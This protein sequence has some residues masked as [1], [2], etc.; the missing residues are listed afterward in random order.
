MVSQRSGAST[1]IFTSRVGHGWHDALR[2]FSPD[3]VRTYLDP[4]SA[5]HELD[6]IP[7]GTECKQ[8]V[9]QTV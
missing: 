1:E 4:K 3:E 2:K 9:L 7:A 6:H 8:A 5:P